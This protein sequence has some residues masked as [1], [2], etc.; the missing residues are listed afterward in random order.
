MGEL[1]HFPATHADTG[2]ER[3]YLLTRELL[4][5]ARQEAAAELV[6]A[7]ASSAMPRRTPRMIPFSKASA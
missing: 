6:R 5:A 4:R 1:I 3:A 2:E 7:P